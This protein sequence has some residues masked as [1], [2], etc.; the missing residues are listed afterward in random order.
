MSLRLSARP[1][2]GDGT[3]MLRKFRIVVLLYIL[4]VVALTTWSTRARNTDWNE[5]L[6]VVVYPIDGEN[7][8]NTAEYIRDLTVDRFE[9]IETSMRE[10][11]R[12]FKVQLEKPVDIKLAPPVATLPPAPP[13]SANPL[14]IALWSLRL[15]FWAWRNDTFDGPA[16][17]RLFAVYYDPHVRERLAHSLGL[18]KGFLGVVHGFGE[19][20][21][22]GRNNVVLT[23]EMLHTL[24]ASDK[25]DPRTNEAVFPLGFAEPE[26]SPLY[27]QRRA[28]IMAGRIPLAAGTS[29]MPRSLAETAI[30]ATTAFEIGWVD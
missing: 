20:E 18:Q 19:R 8:G 26:R 27:P 30:G 28:E 15:R 29:R 6:W 3:L 7:N 10:Q 14:A 11:A 5:P 17:I 9:P 25:Y 12:R 24:G 2:A 13:A 16:D 1:G 4:L 23:H 21:Y 22:D